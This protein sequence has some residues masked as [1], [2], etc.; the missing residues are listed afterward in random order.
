MGEIVIGSRGSDLAMTQSRHVAALLEAAHPGLRARIAIISTRGDRVLDTPLA[1]IGGKGLFTEELEA[2]LLDGSID[3]AVHSLKDLPTALP[4]GLCVA[5]V[6]PRE[7]PRDALV[8]AEASGLDDLPRGARVG[9]SSLRRRAQLL[10]RR[11]DLGIVDLRGNV[12]TRLRKL[13]DLG[14]DAV[15]LAAAGLRRLGLEDRVTEYLEADAMLPAPGQGALGIE[16][17]AGDERVRAL[18]APL[19][20]AAAAAETD[21]ERALLAALGGG[22]QVPVGARARLDGGTIHLDACVC[23]ADG[24]AVSRAFASGPA[25]DA[26][27]LGARVAEALLEQGAA[28]L[29]ARAAAPADAAARRPLAGRRVVVTRPRA[30]AGRLEALLEDAGAAVHAFPTIDIVQREAVALPGPPGAYAWVVFTSANAVDALDA[31]LR[32]AGRA[33]AEFAGTPV[34]AIGPGTSAALSRHGVPVGL[35]PDEAVAEAVAEALARAGGLAG[36]RVLFPRGN[37]ARTVIPDALRAQGAEVE[38]CV[39]YDTRPVRHDAAALDALCAFQPEFIA[40]ASASAV[41]CFVAGVPEARR[42]ALFAAGRAAVIGPVTAAAAERHGIPP[43]VAARR[44]DLPGLVE[45]IVEAAAG[46]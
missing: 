9:T 15:V 40:F 32:R 42:A 30:G 2:G 8:C 27:R 44:H 41:D 38:E 10:A 11:P 43:G 39:V 5:A 28:D 19:H 29:I 34:C 21:A 17:R 4:E 26:A 36:A 7:D 14:I 18:L 16:A 24:T 25:A 45:A 37:L 31:G 33:L 20:D 12:P 22:C 6:P 1:K 13:G 35:T 46:G 23:A 3:I